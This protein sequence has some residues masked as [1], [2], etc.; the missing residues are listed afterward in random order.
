M[1][2]G[3]QAVP[4]SRAREGERHCEEELRL[5]WWDEG[6]ALEEVAT[7]ATCAQPAERKAAEVGQTL[8]VVVTAAGLRE[9]ALQHLPGRN[10]RTISH[11]S[12]G[13]QQRITG[14]NAR[15]I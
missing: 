10:W 7:G 5:C 15:T 9:E 4:W 14:S 8:T 2:A 11:T 1:A 13:E 3:S 12:G 6:Q